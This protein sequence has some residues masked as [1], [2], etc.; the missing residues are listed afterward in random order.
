MNKIT[1]REIRKMPLSCLDSMAFF[2][3]I[4]KNVDTSPLSYSM[5]L[6]VV[7]PVAFSEIVI[8]P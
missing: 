7:P 8:L 5:T 6:K 4:G 3:I 2:M 1:Y